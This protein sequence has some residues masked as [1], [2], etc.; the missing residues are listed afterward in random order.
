MEVQAGSGQVS[1]GCGSAPAASARGTKPR[2]RTSGTNASSLG[3][4]S[5]AGTSVPASHSR[6]AGPSLAVDSSKG[7]ACKYRGVRQRPWG[8]FAA[9]IRDPGSVAA[10]SGSGGSSRS[11]VHLNDA[12]NLGPGSHGMDAELADMAGVLLMLHEGG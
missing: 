5:S 4:G 8:K 2:C 12:S 11:P 6:R 7:G 10:G 9:E 1:D 3:P